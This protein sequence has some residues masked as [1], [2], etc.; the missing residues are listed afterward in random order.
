MLG[1]KAA[2]LEYSAAGGRRGMRIEG[3]GDL[4]IEAMKGQGGGTVT[5]RGNPVAVVPA[6]PAVVAI[7][8]SLHYNDNGMSWDVSG[9]N[10]FFSAFTYQA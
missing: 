7:S 6:T 10:G 5:I 9:R 2:K 1:V 3:I 4:D 8:H